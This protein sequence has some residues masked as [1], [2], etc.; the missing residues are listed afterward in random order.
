MIDLRIQLEEIE[1]Q[2]QNLKPA[3]YEACE[4]METDQIRRERALIYGVVA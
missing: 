3:F 2:I 4:Q 1:R